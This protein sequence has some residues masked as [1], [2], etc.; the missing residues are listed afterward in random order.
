MST[1]YFLLNNLF[2][3]TCYLFAL[4]FIFI[5]IKD[6]KIIK[7]NTIYMIN[8]ISQL[9]FG[10]IFLISYIFIFGLSL[11]PFCFLMILNFI[12]NIFII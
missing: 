11:I 12:Q 8:K 1:D 9:L 5:I 7:K 10:G 3:L 4:S 2:L 6:I